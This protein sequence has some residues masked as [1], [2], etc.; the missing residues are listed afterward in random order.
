MPNAAQSTLDID[1]RINQH[2]RTPVKTVALKILTLS[3][4]ACAI[5]PVLADVSE[6]DKKAA[7]KLA[8]EV[9]VSCHGP[10]GRST[11]VIFPRLAGQTSAYLEAQLKAFRD[12]TRGDPDAIAYMWGM[13][14]QLNDNTIV[15]LADYYAQQKPAGGTQTN[16][17]AIAAGREIFEKGIP[18]L[19]IPAC[20]TCHGKGAVGMGAFPRL[21]GQHGPYLFKQMLVIQNVLRSAPVMHGIVKDLTPTQM[22]QVAAYLESL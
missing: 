3:M 6:F 22:Q 14:S 4:L 11:S 5:G 20:E 18:S 13:A 1:V 19:Q 8:T 9:C 10:G 21:A 16:T 17:A 12:Q 15:A 7:T 2:V